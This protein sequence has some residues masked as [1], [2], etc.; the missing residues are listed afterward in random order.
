MYNVCL[1]SVA[2][3]LYLFVIILYK[4][5]KLSSFRSLFFIPSSPQC[6]LRHSFMETSP[7]RSINQS[8][9]VSIGWAMHHLTSSIA[10]HVHIALVLFMSVCVNY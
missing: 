5:L 8:L 9:F 10:T 3:K 4:V 7:K 6:T 2:T 1:F